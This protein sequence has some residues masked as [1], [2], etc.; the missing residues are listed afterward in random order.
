VVREVAGDK[1]LAHFSAVFGDGD[2]EFEAIGEAGE[3]F[4][5]VG[6]KDLPANWSD[7]VGFNGFPKPVSGEIAEGKIRVVLVVVLADEI[8]TGGEAVADFLAP[9]DMVGRGEAFVDEIEGG[10][11]QQRFVRLLMR[12]AFLN[13]SGSDVHVVKS[14]DGGGDKHD[15]RRAEY[16]LGWKQEMRK[17]HKTARHKIQEKKMSGTGPSRA[18]VAMLGRVSFQ[19]P[20]PASPISPGELGW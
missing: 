4:A 9:R 20:A 3:D 2:E 12:R 1:C 16:P 17:R 5:D 6:D 8:E 7:A 15:C 18:D 13:R 11:E 14:F 19:E 10:H